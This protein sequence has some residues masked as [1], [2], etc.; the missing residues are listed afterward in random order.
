MSELHATNVAEVTKLIKSAKPKSSSLDVLPVSL[1]KKMPDVLAPTLSQITNASFCTGV[2]P[3]VPKKAVVTPSLKKPTL[4]RNEFKNYRPVS[5]LPFEAKLMEKVALKR[6]S[7]H[8]STNNLHEKLQSAYRQMHSTETALMIVQHD[9]ST[10]LD[11]SKGVL[12][13]LL[14]LSSAFDT[15]DKSILLNILEGRL[16]I[17][18]TALRWFESYMTNRTQRVVIDDASSEEKDLRYGVSQGSVLGP[19]LFSIYTSPLEDIIKKY[20]VKY[21]KFADD[22]QLY[23]TY[24]PNIPGDREHALANLTDCIAEVREWMILHKLKLNDTKTEFMVALSSHH[25]KTFGMPDCIVIGDA[26]IRPTQHV[27]NLGAHFD[28]HMSMDQHINALCKKCNYHLRRIGSIRPYITN[29]VC[30]MLVRSLVL[31]NLDYCN[32]LLLDVPDCLI[33]RLQ[34]IQNRAARLVTRT[35][36]RHHITPVL[37]SLHWLPVQTRIHYKVIVYVYK[38]LNG[39]APD[40]LADLLEYD[41]RHTGLRQLCD[42]LRL[43]VPQTAKCVGKRAFGVT[44]PALWNALPLSLRE[45]PNLQLFKKTLKTYLFRK[46]YY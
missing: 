21:H 33:K 18:G 34:R 44:A 4:N 7:E 30:N 11:D 16:G 37:H 2:V 29:S 23:T 35:P 27:K 13:V 42:R 28:I 32:A 8:M 46:Y 6:L 22:L 1:L 20:N 9:I 3:D 39:L 15:I 36:I 25:L 38:A 10:A 12:L 45:V 19:S 40:Y 17:T 24:N 26:D 41:Q 43:R 31:S 14:D 5:S